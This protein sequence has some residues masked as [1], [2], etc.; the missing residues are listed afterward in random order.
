MGEW[1][2]L[3]VISD[4]MS[5]G[6][7]VTRMNQCE[8]ELCCVETEYYLCNAKTTCCKNEQSDARKSELGKGNASL[9]S[10]RNGV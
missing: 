2:R 7:E 3:F 6:R 10:G 1:R 5:A 4:S 9:T 8:Q